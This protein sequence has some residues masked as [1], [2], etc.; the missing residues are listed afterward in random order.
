MIARTIEK[1]QAQLDA[2]DKMD[3]LRREELLKLLTE[4]KDEVNELA[5]TDSE[6]AQS[7]ASF[8]DATAHEATRKEPNPELLDISVKGLTTS[9]NEFEQSHPK[10]VQLVN[11]FCQMLANM[12][13]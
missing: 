1:I 2:A 7:I 3:P 13:I 10:L 8:A 6:R 12:G 4:L 5:K 9:V 11:S